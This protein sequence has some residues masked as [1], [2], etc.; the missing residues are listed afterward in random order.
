MALKRGD[1]VIVSQGE[2]GRPR[3]VVI[4]QA[5]E[6]SEVTTS[7]LACPITSTLM[8]RLPVRPV[9]RPD[10]NNG[11]QVQSQIMTDKLFTARRDRVR[12][13]IGTLDA[14]TREELDRALL[15]VLGLARR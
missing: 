12:R 8:E 5:D 10:A 4:V 7:Y 15:V 11:L 14:P 13:V 1:I 9:I 3:P 6:L 2:L